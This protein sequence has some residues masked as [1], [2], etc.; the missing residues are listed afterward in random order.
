VKSDFEGK[1]SFF[2]HYKSLSNAEKTKIRNEIELNLLKKLKTTCN[3]D[4][5]IDETDPDEVK[6][7]KLLLDKYKCFKK[8]EYVFYL[9]YFYNWL[10]HWNNYLLRKDTFEK[11]VEFV[12][13]NP[14]D[15]HRLL[16][17][18]SIIA[19]RFGYYKKDK[20]IYDRKIIMYIKNIS[21]KVTY[22]AIEL[23]LHRY[24]QS[25]GLILPKLPVKKGN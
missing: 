4:K 20:T 2:Q 1:T 11:D 17:Y 10:F 15:W 9:E 7:I 3:Y 8:S 25:E 21:I 22:K 19:K 24:K 16:P 12:K 23:A 6:E 5:D 13:K 14:K 18:Y